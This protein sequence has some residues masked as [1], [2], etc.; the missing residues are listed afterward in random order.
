M[1]RERARYAAGVAAVTAVRCVPVAGTLDNLRT[2][3]VR[4]THGRAAATLP[5]VRRACSGYTRVNIRRAA[6]RVITY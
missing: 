3:S 1:S 2:P 5:Q 6:R 4:N